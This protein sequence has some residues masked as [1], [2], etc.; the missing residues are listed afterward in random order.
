LSRLQ[1]VFHVKN[2]EQKKIIERSV[3]IPI[4]ANQQQQ[5]F[6][7]NWQLDS[8]SLKPGEYL[9]YYLQVW[10]NDGVNGHK[11]TR[12]SVYTFFVPD[13][14]QL[15]TDISKAQAQTEEKIEEGAA[16]AQELS[17]QINDGQQK[18]K[19]KQS[20]D[21]QD[22]K[23]LEDIVEQ[24]KNLEKLLNELKQQNKLLEDKKDA[25]TEQDERIR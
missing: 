14:D 9:E 8:M 19:G 7:Y 5:S 1:L 4:G 10:D 21:W 16:K 6:F 23:K 3:A 13:K 20:L 24:K 22:K 12:Y 11:S 2:V 15:V 17:Q 18:L 25:F